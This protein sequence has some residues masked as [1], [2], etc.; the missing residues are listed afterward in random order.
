MNTI[1]QAVRGVSTN[2]YVLAE[3]D[4]DGRERILEMVIALAADNVDNFMLFNLLMQVVEL[5]MQTSTLQ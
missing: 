1:V 5:L 2:A 3:Y 4:A